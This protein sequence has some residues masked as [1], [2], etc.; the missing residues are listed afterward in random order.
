MEGTMDRYWLLTWTTYGTWLPGDRRGFVSDVRDGPGPEVRHNI[1]GTPYDADDEQVRRRA[2]GNLVGEPVWLTSEQA[3]IVAEQ[4]RQTAAYRGW[5]LLAVAV[6]AN[7]VHLVVGVPGDPDPAKL[8]HDFKSYASRALKAQGHVPSG[9]RW[10]TESGS[11]RKLL[12][13]RAVEAAIAYVLRQQKPLVVWTPGER[14]VSTPCTTTVAGSADGQSRCTAQSVNTPRSPVLLLFLLL[15][16]QPANA[17][18]PWHLSGWQGRAVLEIPKPVADA[19]VD[20]AA[21]RLLCQGLAKAD[22]SDYRVLDAAGKPVPFQITFHD[23]ARYSLISFQAANPRQKFFVYFGNP[24]APA[25]KEQVIVNT[26]IGAGA[27]KGP[28]VP[29]QGLVLETWER[30]VEKDPKT[31]AVKHPQNVPEMIKL[32]AD[33]KVKL[34]ARYQ[35]RISDGFNPFGSS[36]N[37]ISIYRGWIDIP[38]TGTYQFCTASSKASFS[39]ID[40]AK[41]VH[42]PG[43]HTA[44]RGSR[45]EVNNSVMLVK[46]PHYIEYYHETVPLE[47]MAFLGWRP[48]ADEGP[49]SAIP[50]SVIPA[51]HEAVVKAYESPK[52]AL[53][54]FEPVIADSVW[55]IERSEGQYTRIRF[56]TEKPSLPANA[57]C[58]WDFGD[59]LGATGSEVEH[60]YLTMGTFAVSLMIKGPQG[61]QTLRWPLN[62]FEIEHVTDQ[63][64]EGSP[65]D[66]AGLVLKYDR[67]KLNA[68]ALKEMAYLLAETEQP[69]EAVAVGKEYLGRFGAKRPALEV[70]RVRRLLADCAIRLG[71]GG[72]KEAIANYQAS[73]VAETPA[74]EKL[75]VLA[76]LLHLV[77]IERRLPEEADK[78]LAQVE[79]TW[80]AGTDTAETRAAYRR[81]LIA[82]GDVLLW[83]KKPADAVDFYRRAEALG[84]FIPSQVRKARIGAYPNGIRELIANGSHGAA[85]DIVN[86]WDESFPTDKVNGQTF[87]WR[88]KLLALRGRHADAVRYFRLLIPRGGSKEKAMAEGTAFESEARWLLAESLEKTGKADEAKIEL[89]RLVKTGFKDPFRDKAVAKLKEGLK[90]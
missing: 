33:A 78:V 75:D 61:T 81:A 64:K 26:A 52:G 3:A 57:T 72:L 58:Q 86:R 48:S 2:M 76:R 69:A 84:A 49:F 47:H 82:M 68:D 89:A 5:S 46:G 28:W 24:Q 71:E 9:G 27:P 42:W 53:P 29:H 60:V 35:R 36:D 37:Y 85:L 31:G 45:G 40:G 16:G 12:D 65:K 43:R 90:K 51:P 25:A 14:G 17:A 67:S 19:G 41:L 1:P 79:K 34:G 44:E 66:Y 54:R 32:L 13:E 55:P 8:L 20:T 18:D 70:S 62:V 77:G 23:A 63:F 56:Q 74:P 59:G 50:E 4:F 22:G 39:F 38:R 10:W 21:V 30:P 80:K 88:A 11:K 83:N 7:H 87:F 6:M 73:L 15:F